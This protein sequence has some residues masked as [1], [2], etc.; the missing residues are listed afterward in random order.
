[1]GNTKERRFIFRSPSSSGDT[2]LRFREPTETAADV[3][4][5]RIVDGSYD[6]PFL[7]E[8]LE[9]RAMCFALD[10][11]TQSEMRLDDPVALVSEYTRKMMGF[12]L[13][14]RRPQRILMIGLGGGSLVKF[15]HRHLPTTHITA[16]EIDAQVI[17]LRSH[18]HV[19]PDDSR[20]RVVNE[21]GARHVAAMAHTDQRTDVML[22]DAYDQRGIANAVVERPFLEHSRRVL[23][24]R[25]VFVMNLAE[26]ADACDGYIETVRSV[27]GEPVIAVAME[28]TFNVVVFAGGALRDRRRLMTATRNSHRI[29]GRL[30][31]HFPTLL[32][33]TTEYQRRLPRRGERREPR[34]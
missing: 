34:P 9:F 24:P 31:L 10:G 13:F 16:V 18:F 32:R 15:C 25:G 8:D 2:L 23:A 28:H 33:R 11:S 21:D 26:D 27:F 17:A 29:Q 7:V 5:G 12:L 19:P 6:K 3:L 4:F 20:L 1:M 30:G 14:R 22:V